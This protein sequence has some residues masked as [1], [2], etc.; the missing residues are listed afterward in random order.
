MSGEQLSLKVSNLLDVC[1]SK[2]GIT[3]DKLCVEL[4]IKRQSLWNWRKGKTLPRVSSIKKICEIG[5]VDYNKF[6]TS[7]EENPLDSFVDIESL[8]QNYRLYLEDYPLQVAYCLH[9]CAAYVV[10]NLRSA[11]LYTKTIFQDFPPISRSANCTITITF[12][13]ADFFD[14]SLSI[15]GD[16]DAIHLKYYKHTSSS[17]TEEVIYSEVLNEKNIQQLINLI[18]LTP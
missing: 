4:N 10:E 11:G 3:V 9:L 8:I 1:L 14:L 17:P 15:Y 6:V 18:Q 7:T 2:P 16:L 13:D 12:K 5:A